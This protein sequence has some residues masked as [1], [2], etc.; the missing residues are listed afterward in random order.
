MET[1]N[2]YAHL[3]SAEAKAKRYAYFHS[4]VHR[5]KASEQAK[6][7]WALRRAGLKPP[8]VYKK[9]D[10]KPELAVRAVLESLQLRF[11]PQAPVGPYLFDFQLPDQK[12]FIEVQGE[13]WHNLPRTVAKDLAKAAYVESQHPDCRIAYIPEIA[14]LTKGGIELCLSRFLKKEDQALRQLDL[15]KLVVRDATQDAANDVLERSHYLPRLRKTTRVIHG[16][17][18]GDE[19]IGVMIY[20]LPTYYGVSAQYG[21][22]PRN[23]LDM[24][25]CAFLPGCNVPNLFSWALS[26]SV[27]LIRQAMPEVALLISFADPHFGH[28]GSAYKASGWEQDGITAPS[29]Y[30]V[31]K[32]GLI[33]HKRTLWDHAIKAGIPEADY[34]RQFGF[35]RVDTLGKLRFIKWIR[36]KPVPQELP[37]T[38]MMNCV[39]CPE[40]YAVTP[41]AYARALKKNGFY[42]CHRCSIKFAWKDE[43]YKSRRERL[44][45]SDKTNAITAKCSD[46]GDEKHVKRKTYLIAVQKKGVYR[47]HKCAMKFAW[48]SGVYKQLPRGPRLYSECATCGKRTRHGSYRCHQCSLGS[49]W[50]LRLEKLGMIP[51]QDDKVVAKCVDCGRE[52]IVKRKSYIFAIRRRGVYRC[53]GCAIKQMAN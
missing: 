8:P 40:Q 20:G 34:A 5:R 48:H 14:T 3:E 39:D 36:E 15:E 38:V 16:I 43:G 46:C 25:R 6:R 13:Y 24:V 19:L 30:Y 32:D 11:V 12:I 4:D 1:N 29:Y 21:L 33:I 51:D 18:N 53:P 9:S 45:Y 37:K 7:T 41:K 50:R 42:R 17:F 35:G 31:D 23:V 28:H 26:R 52:R 22:K 27:N 2:R 49:V 44:D 47:C 10:T